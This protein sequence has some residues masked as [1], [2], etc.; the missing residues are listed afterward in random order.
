[1]RWWRS[2][3]VIMNNKTIILE[4]DQRHFKHPPPST[5]VFK[6][7]QFHNRI[8]SLWLGGWWWSLKILKATAFGK[9]ISTGLS[10]DKGRE[11]LIISGPSNAHCIFVFGGVLSMGLVRAVG[12]TCQISGKPIYTMNHCQTFSCNIFYR[13]QDLSNHW[14]Y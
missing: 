2:I 4:F 13:S 5:L 12:C 8:R 3:V 7:W 6:M 11:C 9:Q 14:A 1:M 10:E